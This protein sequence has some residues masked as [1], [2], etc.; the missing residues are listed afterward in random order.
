MVAHYVLLVGSSIPF[1]RLFFG[2]LPYFEKGNFYKKY[3]KGLLVTCRILKNSSTALRCINWKGS[4]RAFKKTNPQK[5]S[6][7]QNYQL[8]P[9]SKVQQHCY[10]DK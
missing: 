2:N 8:L 7:F 6:F 4:A 3:C 9:F 5:I 1:I 10:N